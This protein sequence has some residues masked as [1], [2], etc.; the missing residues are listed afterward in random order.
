VSPQIRDELAALHIGKTDQWRTMPLSLDLDEL[1]ASTVD[2]DAA[3]T[4]FGLPLEPLLVGIVGRLAPIKRVDLFLRAAA[5]VAR[6]SASVEFVV[7]GPN[8]VATLLVRGRVH[9]R[10]GHAD[11]ALGDFN[12]ALKLQPTD[13]AALTSRNEGTPV[14]LIEAGVVGVPAVATNAGGQP[15]VVDDER[16]GLIVDSEDPRVIAAEIG[17]V[18]R[19][20]GLRARLGEEARR[21]MTSR[22]GTDEPANAIAELYRSLLN[23]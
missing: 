14:A 4:R 23:R 17:R 15:D 2:R 8:D 3:R 7:A 18:L 21:V 10:Q 11:L 20:D 5:I 22:Y 9:A 16:T 13:V 19:D 6:E 1:K 12:Q